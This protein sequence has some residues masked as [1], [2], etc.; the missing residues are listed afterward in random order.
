V[1]TG[2]TWP[3]KDG[4]VRTLSQYLRKFLHGRDDEDLYQEREPDPYHKEALFK[5]R[6][7]LVKARSMTE[8]EAEREITR[9]HTR[10]S[11]AREESIA[12]TKLSLQRFHDMLARVKD[13][14]TEGDPGCESIKMYAVQ[15]LEESI[16]W[17]GTP[18]D[19]YGTHKPTPKQFIQDEIADAERD[20]LY[21]E[22]EY[23]KVVE[24]TAAHNK[25]IK[26][27]RKTIG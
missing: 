6:E 11:A 8:L 13:W 18:G 5:A 25:T 22:R 12:E 27:L 24:Q 23:A 21:H 9:I 26:V 20:V 19:G 14:N 17:E 3:V 1:A 2:Y 15:Q 4:S 10:N 16:K 7:E